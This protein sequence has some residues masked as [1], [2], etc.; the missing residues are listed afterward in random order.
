MHLFSARQ[1]STHRGRKR[2][3]VL[4]KQLNNTEFCDLLQTQMSM[5]GRHRVRYE[6]GAKRHRMFNWWGLNMRGN[7]KWNI[8]FTLLWCF[9]FYRDRW[10][11]VND[12]IEFNL[13]FTAKLCVTWNIG[14][15]VWTWNSRFRQQFCCMDSLFSFL[16]DIYVQFLK[17]RASHDSFFVYHIVSFYSWPQ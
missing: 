13:K 8:F 9:W 3:Q 10:E 5:S 16:F 2:K 11:L 14:T 17:F 6:K 7:E 12:W 15:S 1:E 4:W